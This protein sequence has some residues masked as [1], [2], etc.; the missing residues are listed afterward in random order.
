M[1]I[2]IQNIGGIQQSSDKYEMCVHILP[3][4]PATVHLIDDL[5]S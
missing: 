5:V 4:L 1:S 2:C 3:V